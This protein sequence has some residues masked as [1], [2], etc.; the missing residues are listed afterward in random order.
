MHAAS[1]NVSEAAP[2]PSPRPRD[3]LSVSR[4][5]FRGG[6]GR[7]GGGRFRRVRGAGAKEARDGFFRRIFNGETECKRTSRNVNPATFSRK[8]RCICLGALSVL[9]KRVYYIR[10]F[11]VDAAGNVLR[12]LLTGTNLHDSCRVF[13]S[14][15]QFAS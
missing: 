3:A 2:P 5:R 4:R 7:E 13:G 1:S 8:R 12:L 11:P 14:P 9:L 15:R 10:N 6:R